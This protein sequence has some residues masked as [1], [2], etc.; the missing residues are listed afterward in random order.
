MNR[1]DRAIRDMEE[2]RH[3]H[4]AWLQW[5][6]DGNDPVCSFRDTV[7]YEEKWVRRYNNTLAVLNKLKEDA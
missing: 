6:R 5:L 4:V 7:K 1:V 3:S 2:A